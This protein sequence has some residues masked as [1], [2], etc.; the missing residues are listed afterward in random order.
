MCLCLYACLLTG[1][2][3]LWGLEARP[4]VKQ[5]YV[6]GSAR[7]GEPTLHNSNDPIT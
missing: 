7:E 2:S 1:E 3:R 6:R 4:Y 5:G